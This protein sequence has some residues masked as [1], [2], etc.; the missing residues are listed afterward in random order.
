MRS[1]PWIAALALAVIAPNAFA[2]PKSAHKTN[3]ALKNPAALKEKAPEIF[4]AKFV[5]TKGTYV[6]EVKRAWAPLGAD[7]FYNLVKNGFFD[8]IKFFRVVPGFVVQFGMHGDPAIL[9]KWRD[10]NI[11]DE[12]VVVGNKKG[13]LTY[14]KAGPNT[15]STQFFINLGEN[16]NLDG[17][18]FPA[19]GH[20]V[21]GM[22]VVDKLY[23][24]Y[25]DGPPSGSGP[26]QGAIAMQGNVYLNKEFPKL[27]SIVTATIV[28]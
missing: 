2:Q 4:K 3:P 9:A 13:F 7:R 11:A 16:S 28:K 14:A 6:V 17:M 10:A 23:S 24:G 19:F 21:Q 15:R 8:E 20:V 18:G 22:D 5:T 26:D 1:L 25:G 12:K 27:D